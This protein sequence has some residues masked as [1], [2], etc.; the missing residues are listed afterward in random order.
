MT[1]NINNIGNCPYVR[2]ND[3]VYMLEV[4]GDV[5]RL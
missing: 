3:D 4:N 2:E 1:L 5:Y